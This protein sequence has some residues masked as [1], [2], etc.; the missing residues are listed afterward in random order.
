MISGIFVPVCMKYYAERM[1]EK[2]RILLLTQFRDFLYSLSASFAAGRHMRDGLA[3]AGEN[4]KRMYDENTP[5]LREITAML[6]QIDESRASEEEVLRD[7]ARRSAI[8][9]IQSFFDTYFICRMTGGDINKVISKSSGILIEKTGIEKEIKTL[10]SQKKFEGNIISVMPVIVI[11]FLNIASPEY[12]EALY[13][14]FMGRVIMTAALAGI[15]YAYYLT[16][17][18]MRIEV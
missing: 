9:D 4:L 6:I 16:Q 1:A 8:E 18:L 3:E 15:V 5:M 11:L 12:I 17:K 14:T 10:T 13:I 2:R 7:F